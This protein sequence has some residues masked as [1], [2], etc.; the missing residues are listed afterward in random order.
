MRHEIKEKESENRQ[1]EEKARQLQASVGQREQILELKS[2][3]N[4]N[5]ANDP[6]KKMKDTAQLL[7]LRD[8][9]KQ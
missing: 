3:K 1:L 9:I 7:K 2:G 4:Q 5:N 6:E 8:I